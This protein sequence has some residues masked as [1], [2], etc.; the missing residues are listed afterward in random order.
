MKG[1]LKVGTVLMLAMIMLF[2]TSV[3][4]YGAQFKFVLNNYS[5]DDSTTGGRAK[6]N[7]GDVYAY[8]TYDATEIVD[9][10]LNNM[11]STHATL[12][13][14]VRDSNRNYATEYVTVDHT[15]NGIT[16]KLKYLNT[17]SINFGGIHYLYSNVESTD[18]WPVNATGRWVP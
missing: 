1:K 16:K 12:N 14:R 3:F 4:A 9:A 11:Y 6:P 18:K 13:F 2:S 17:S 15:D 8:V 7:D 5:S 10:T